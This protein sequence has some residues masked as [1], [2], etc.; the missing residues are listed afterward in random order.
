MSGIGLD[1]VDLDRFRLL[2]SRRP[3]IAER[4]FTASERADAARAKDPVPHLAARF[5]A[6][7]AVMKALEVGIGAFAFREVEVHRAKSGAPG[8]SLSGRAAVLARD[9]GAD[10]WHLSMTHSD[11]VAAASVVAVSAP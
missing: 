8:I 1:V 2:L 10:V 6:K 3:A 9:K 4:V 5:A 11:L 7:E